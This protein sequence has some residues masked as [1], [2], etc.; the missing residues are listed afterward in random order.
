MFTPFLASLARLAAWNTSRNNPKPRRLLG[1]WPGLV[2]LAR[3]EIT[4]MYGTAQRQAA[5]FSLLVCSLAHSRLRGSLP[6]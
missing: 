5:G 4:V 6:M 1:R 2:Y 3:V